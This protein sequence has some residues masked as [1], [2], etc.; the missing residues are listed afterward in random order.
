MK[1]KWKYIYIVLFL[2]AGTVY[3]ENKKIEIGVDE[4]LGKH[5][6]LDV[7]FKTE[8]GK[9]I[10]LKDLLTK[11]T[12]LAFVYYRCPGICS[13]LMTSVTDVINRTSLEP[14]KDYNIIT[15]SMDETEKPELAADAAGFYFKREGKDF[16]HSGALIFINNEGKI[17][18]YLFPGY[19]DRGG[20]R[21]LPFDFKMAV[22][23]T[24]KG[25]VIPTVANMLQFCFSYDPEGKTYVLNFTRIFGAGILLLAAVFIVFVTK[26]QK[27]D[28]KK[29]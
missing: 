24:S 27:K 26:K 14:V 28:L 13:P 21:I 17:C 22:S 11:P 1:N 4:Q 5:V 16:I 20:F 15:I 7:T 10:V 19:T 12:V 23:E 6:P 3:A 2:L 8:Y 18:R 29:R 9:D 25:N